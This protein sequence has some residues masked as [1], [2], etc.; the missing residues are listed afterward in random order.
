MI[1]LFSLE[2]NVLSRRHDELK[3]KLRE[4]LKDELRVISAD[5]LPQ[6]A[7]QIDYFELVY[8][9]IHTRI[10]FVNVISKDIRDSI[11]LDIDRAIL[12]ALLN[13]KSFN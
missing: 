5:Q 11:E 9:C 6:T 3:T 2:P 4:E 7:N 1:S 8:Q 10:N 13:G 12:E